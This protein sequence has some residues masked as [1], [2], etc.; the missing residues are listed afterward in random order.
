MSDND[1]IYAVATARGRAGVAVVR[2]SGPA[3]DRVAAAVAGNCPKPRQAVLRTLRHPL[4]GIDLD[5]AL[6][7][8]FPAPGSFTGENIVEFHIH[9]G[10][11]VGRAVLD[12]V[13]AVAGTRAAEAGEFTRRAFYNERLDLT[14]VEGLADLIAAETESQRR[15]A[16]RQAQG[17]QAEVFSGWRQRLISALAYVEAGI[18]FADEEL[19]ENVMVHARPEVAALASE[20]SRALADQGRGERLRDGLEVAIIGPPNAGKSSLLNVLARRDVAIVSAH[21]GTTR[22]VLEVHL[23]LGGYAVTLVDTAGLRD[24]G[25]EIE[26]EGIRR[27]SV[28]AETADL[29]LLLI[30]AADWPQVPKAT[31]GLADLP[32][33]WRI[34][35]RAD[36]KKDVSGALRLSIKTGEGVDELIR[37]LQAQAE[38]MMGAGESAL[39]TRSRHRDALTRSA[40][41]LA[42]FLDQDWTGR[43]ELAAEELR[44][45]ARALGG[46]TG[47]VGVEDVLGAIFS[48]FC[49]GK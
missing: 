47:Q 44:L 37:R 45:A 40:T 34:I 35:S 38:E 32:H 1:T 6:V 17:R 42:A 23:D 27:A 4:T 36:E 26:A 16:I 28:R 22:D 43:E 33:T 24:A 31:A 13:A 41:H 25:D 19:P 49:I 15:Q 14:A 18:D 5:R 12:A 48:E 11:A 39:I 10:L 29:R 3:A 21:A 9:G 20:I 30:P 2:V 8:W 46:L 7:L